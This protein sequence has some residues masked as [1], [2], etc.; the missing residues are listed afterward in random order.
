MAT[1]VWGAVGVS[2]ILFQEAYIDRWDISTNARGKYGP[3][4]F[5]CFALLMICVWA[6]KMLLYPRKQ[7][8]QES[9]KSNQDAADTHAG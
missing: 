6:I 3:V 4:N 2:V 9:K 5:A 7:G 8:G 1:W